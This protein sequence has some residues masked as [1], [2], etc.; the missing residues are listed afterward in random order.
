MK[1]KAHVIISSKNESTH[2]P[3]PI[4]CFDIISRQEMISNVNHD[5]TRQ[6]LYLPGSND[7]MENIT[8][9]AWTLGNPT[10][11]GLVQQRCQ[12][13]GNRSTWRGGYSLSQSVKSFF[14]SRFW[15]TFELGPRISTLSP[16]SGQSGKTV[17][18]LFQVKQLLRSQQGATCQMWKQHQ[19][20][21]H[22]KLTRTCTQNSCFRRNSNVCTEAVEVL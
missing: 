12:F 4:S 15:R 14:C 11:P 17:A 19:A 3:L 13:Q 6:E 1:N 5:A 21:S 2:Q 20:A 9:S 18:Q 22:S 16:G 8:G 7:S 10:W